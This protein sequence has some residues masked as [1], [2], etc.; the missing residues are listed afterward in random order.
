MCW[1]FLKKQVLPL[2]PQKTKFTFSQNCYGH[3]K[4]INKLL[5]R[6][7][8]CR[9]SLLRR[10]RWQNKN[11]FVVV[12]VARRS[13]PSSIRKSFH[14]VVA[15][16]LHSPSLCTGKPQLTNVENRRSASAHKNKTSLSSSLS[17]VARRRHRSKIKRSRRSCRCPVIDTYNYN[18]V[19][20]H[21]CRP[22]STR[23]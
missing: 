3:K 4:K 10:L 11:V 21:V 5:R 20:G 16:A 17:L 1:G 15:V 13:P 23:G 22:R 7:R 8:R 9:L 19:H 6:R 2:S 14:I 18:H 12:V